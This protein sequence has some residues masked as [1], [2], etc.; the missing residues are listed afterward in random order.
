M[1]PRSMWSGMVTLGL[2][3]VPMKLYST[4]EHGNEIKFNQVHNACSKQIAQKRWCGECER[5]VAYDELVKGYPMGEAMVVI[6][7]AEIEAARP[8]A[9]RTIPIESFVALDAIDP[10]YVDTSYFM[11]PETRAEAAFA[12]LRE[13]MVEQEVVALGRIVLRLREHLCVIRPVGAGLLL[14]TLH[15]PESVRP[16][17]AAP[18][19]PIAPAMLKQAIQLV[20]AVTVEDPDLSSYREKYRDEIMA[21]IEAR[22]EGL[23]LPVAAPAAAPEGVDLMQALEQS[24]AA[25]RERA[26]G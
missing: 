9:S 15:W 26:A 2:V 14:Q 12:L 24:L 8:E 10:I 4:L 20:E 22:A 18:D 7:P 11:A 3:S 21:M 19:A 16:V 6:D 17:M 13:A 1:A 5:E 23:P 25:A